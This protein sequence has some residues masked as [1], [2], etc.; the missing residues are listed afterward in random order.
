M[1]ICMHACLCIWLCMHAYVYVCVCI[2]VSA[3]SQTYIYTCV[4]VNICIRM[5]TCIF[6]YFVRM[7]GWMYAFIYTC[8]YII[9]VKITRTHTHYIMD[10]LY[11]FV[12]FLSKHCFENNNRTTINSKIVMYNL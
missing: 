6:M 11:S 2:Y 4:C 12:L 7:G 1:Y 8:M 5:Y 3:S 10:L 9:V